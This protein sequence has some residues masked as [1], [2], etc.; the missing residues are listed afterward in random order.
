MAPSAPTSA[1]ARII[2]AH[3]PKPAP[4]PDRAPAAERAFGRA[5]RHAATPFPGLG[6]T[7]GPV[8]LDPDR[9]LTAGIEALPEHGL[10][11]VLEDSS[12]RRGLIGV[13]HGLI[14][15][16]IEVQTTGRVESGTLSP[17]PV[18]EIDT[19][20]SRDFLDLLLSAFAREV[21]GIP[22]RDWPDRM[23]FGSRVED[24]QQVT[25]LLPDCAYHIF[26]A[27]VQFDGTDRGAEV[28]FALP[29]D[30]SLIPSEPVPADAGGADRMAKWQSALKATL[31]ATPMTLDAVLLRVTQTIGQVE[32]MKVGD[33]IPLTHSDIAKVGLEDQAGRRV[34]TGHLGQR[35][36]KRA[37]RVPGPAPTPQ[38]DVEDPAVMPAPNATGVALHAPE[39]EPEPEDQAAS[40]V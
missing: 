22:V 11:G 36:G 28:M 19:A 21:S 38:P 40:A 29:V 3:R 20:L 26:R 10:S 2:S 31:A 32:A 34:L 35:D 13:S 25:L 4:K 15:A 16:L 23:H 5:L 8:A 24:R 12:G 6:L 30:P 7:L 18:T 14:D 39:P 9:D 1:K 33:L 17:R 27:Q 37:I